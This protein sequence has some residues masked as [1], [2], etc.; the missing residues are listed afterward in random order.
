MADIFNEIEEDLRRERMARLWKRFGPVLV[1]IAVLIV[2]AI[3]GW[4]AWEWYS[5][6]QAQ[7]AGARY[8][9]AL[10]L[11]RDGKSAEAGTALQS[12]VG[13]A[14]GGYALL[15][16][17]RAATELAETD[18][19]GAAAAF[20]S[21]A[22]DIA[23]PAAVRDLARIRAALILV[24]TGSQADVASRVEPLAAAGNNWRHSSTLR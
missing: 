8:E 7:E 17:F 20:E 23:V 14:P 13:E 15:A 1:A 4:R 22:Q 2:A 10:Q 11:A 12:L 18:K 21:I 16:R 19:P 5:A 9:A 3:A 6:R 24:D